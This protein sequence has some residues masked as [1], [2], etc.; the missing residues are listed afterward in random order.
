MVGALLALL[1]N[2]S[3]AR[4]FLSSISLEEEKFPLYWR[5][6]LCVHTLLWRELPVLQ[7]SA[8]GFCH[9]ANGLSFRSSDKESAEQKAA[10]DLFTVTNTLIFRHNNWKA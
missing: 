9:Y 5:A 3:S 6:P 10:R 8:T 2:S 4:V 1:A 7:S